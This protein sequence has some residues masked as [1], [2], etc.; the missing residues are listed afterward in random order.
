MPVGATVPDANWLA[1][2]VEEAVMSSSDAREA[3]PT[4]GV[5]EPAFFKNRKAQVLMMAS[6][7][8]AGAGLT[9]SGM[10][11]PSSS[12]AALLVVDSIENGTGKCMLGKTLRA[13]GRAASV[14]DGYATGA[15]AVIAAQ[16]RSSIGPWR[17][18]RFAQVEQCR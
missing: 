8:K 18:E 13:I 17:A 2:R 10:F 16:A 4:D 3:V 6:A 14:R 7:I 1:R 9:R 12:S 11:P 5:A 15:K